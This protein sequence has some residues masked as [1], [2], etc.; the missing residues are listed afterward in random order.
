MNDIVYILDGLPCDPDNSDDIK[1][2]IDYS[3]TRRLNMFDITIDSV[4]FVNRDRERII[5]HLKTKGFGHGMRFDVQFTNTITMRYYLDFTENLKWTEN[6]ITCKI[7]RFKANDNFIDNAQSLSWRLVNFQD[8]DFTEVDF[9][10]IQDGQ[11]YLFIS[12]TISMFTITRELIY[13]VQQVAEGIADLQASLPSASVSGPVV[14]V[15]AI[16]AASTKLAARLVYATSIAIA[17]VQLLIQIIEI[18][19]PPL[20]QLKDIQVWRLIE[21]G[22]QHLGYTLDSTALTQDLRPLTFLGAPIK[23]LDIKWLTEF[24]IPNDAVFTDGFPNEMDSIP[25][26]GQAIETIC[27]MFNLRYRVANGV[28]KIERRD[29]FDFAQNA[30][31]LRYNLQDSLQMERGLSD[32]YWKRYLMVWAKDSRDSF[33]YDYTIGHIAE[34]DTKVIVLDEP[35]LNLIKGL[36]QVRNP[37]STGHRKRELTRVER[38]IKNVMAPAVDLF[39][40]GAFSNLINN[41][42][43]VLVTSD[44]YFSNNKLL[45]KQGAKISPDQDS[46]LAAINILSDWHDSNSV[47]NRVKDVLENVPIPMNKALFLLLANTNFITLE[48]GTLA[49]LIRV[50]WSEKD[51]EASV[52]MELPS[53]FN[54][55]LTQTIINNGGV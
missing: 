35:Q 15:G 30:I 13:A 49:E 7:K 43:N 37:F 9:M 55:N 29:F 51:H 10:V 8:S 39:T 25:T 22:C 50:E 1:F 48:D 52:T 24:L 27:E 11:N 40:G 53:E 2:V 4:T 46:K 31:Q 14:N 17:M 36:E 5:Q 20:R 54:V 28:V 44:V 34:L 41:R 23:S 18:V 3:D 42:L 26:L 16:L 33:T 6:Q 38:F 32:G 47:Q 12:L 45:W 19:F 21:K